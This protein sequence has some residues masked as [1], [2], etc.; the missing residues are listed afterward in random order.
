MR[1]RTKIIASIGPSS[2]SASKLNK[3]IQE[4]TDVFR[5]NLSHSNILQAKKI[6]EQLK[7]ESDKLNRPV[8]TMIDL[9]G[10][11]I[12]IKD[13]GKKTHVQ[14]KNKDQFILDSSLPEGKGTNKVVGITYKELYRHL[15]K[16]DEILLSDA[17]IKL[18][19]IGIKQNK[20]ITVVKRGGRL[21]PHQ[22]LNKKG[23]GLTLR[24]ITPKDKSDLQQ[25]LE[26]DIDYIA[27]SFVKDERDIKEIKKLIGKKQI[28]VIAKIERAE[29]LLKIDEI[30]DAS[31]GILVARGDLGVEIGI[32]QLPAVQ[33]RLIRK[34]IALDKIVI[35]ATQMMESMINNRV[36]T[37]A[38]VFDVAN[39]V[40]SGVDAIML[41]AETAIGRY[42][43]DVVQEACRICEIAEKTNRNITKVEKKELNLTSVDQVIAF[44]AVFAADNSCIK[45]IACLTETGSTPRWMSR[46][47]SNIPIYAMTKSDTASRRICMY[48]GVYSIKINDVEY[49]HAR[50]NK[51]VVDLM[52]EK[53]AVKKGDFVIITKGDLMGTS[54]STNALKIVEV[55][56]LV[57][58]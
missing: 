58:A 4:G 3:M 48:K 47:Q 23:G 35:V 7:V 54:G 57:D 24:G 28:G 20:I 13:F 15:D 12:R 46:V 27:V 42:P 1:K 53:G 11:K 21:K 36:P 41:S 25:A 18:E 16:G 55:G 34:S 56:N 40:T 29:A 30:A 26:I 39:A 14:L 44:S 19:V 8:A 38:E 52:V 17:L 22:G 32:E 33:D 43:V 9:Q 51:Q 50:A 2:S 5:I 6:V 31:D 10:Q 45:A 49:D 37:R